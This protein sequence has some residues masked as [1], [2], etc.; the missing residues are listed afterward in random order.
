[1]LHLHSDARNRCPE[2]RVVGYRYGLPA[3]VGV[4]YATWLI[5]D[6]QRIRVNGTV[7]YVEILEKS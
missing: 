3:V 2:I 4:D 5:Q 7:G 6:G 1:M